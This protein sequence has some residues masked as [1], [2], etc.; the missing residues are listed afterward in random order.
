MQTAT[1]QEATMKTSAT[2]LYRRLTILAVTAAL[3][4]TVVS[5]ASAGI[6]W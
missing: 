3:F 6:R 4:A 1:T 5:E 2:H